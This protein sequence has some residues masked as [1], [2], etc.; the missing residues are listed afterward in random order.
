MPGP[1]PPGRR[2]PAP[3]DGD[4]RVELAKPVGPLRGWSSEVFDLSGKLTRTRSKTFLATWRPA[5]GLI[6]V[7]LVD[8]PTGWRAYFCTDPSASVAE[9]LETIADRFSLEKDQP[10][11][12]SRHRWCGARRP[13]YHR[14]R[15]AA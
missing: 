13:D 4:H 6:R 7:V 14:R 12:T 8:E 1:K 15:G 10:H 11:Y 9:I 3:T 2:G 5:G